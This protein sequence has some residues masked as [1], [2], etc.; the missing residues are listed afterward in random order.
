M[1]SRSSL[2]TRAVHAGTPSPRIDRAAVTPIYQCTVFEQGE[3]Q[4]YSDIRYPRLNNLPNH[5]VLHARLADLEGTERALVT[6]SGMAAITTTLLS[7]LRPGDHLLAQPALYGG[8]FNFIRDQLQAL[9]I[10]V[11]WIDAC[12][13]RSWEP[14]L[15]PTTRAVYT[16]AIANPCTQVADH[17]ALLDFAKAQGLVS[18]C[19]ATFA[20]PVNFRPAELGYDLVLHSAT[21]Y[22]NGHSDLTAGVIAGSAARIEAILPQLNLLG[23]TLDP[24][25]CFLLE[26]GLRT[27]VLRVERQNANAL[28]IAQHLEGHAAIEAVL[29]PGLESHPQHRQARELFEGC[30]GMLAFKV[31]GD[32]AKAAAFIDHL[33][34]P[35]HGPSLGGPE[36]LVTR[37]VT[38]SHLTMSAAERAAAGVTDNMVRMS[39]GIEGVRDLI[40]D[41]DQALGAVS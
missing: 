37:P 23:G 18:L 15:R 29:Y 10:S 17:G 5:Q 21:K 35:L 24:H 34:I 33:Q 3:V 12:D 8:T 20:T 38:T 22:L 31:R 39:V 36:T 4:S 40:D 19:D 1:Q 16:E 14:L 2:A 28:A 32:G 27:L 11:D 7:V 25:A 41:L 9:G 26:R 6:A 30:G 13:P